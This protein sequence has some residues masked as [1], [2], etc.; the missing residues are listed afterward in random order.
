MNIKFTAYDSATGQ[1][2]YS[3]TASDPEALETSEVSILPGV[4][5]SDGWIDNGQH[6]LPP[7]KPS[8][9]HVFDY[10]TKQWV[11][12]RTLQALKDAKWEEI[13]SSRTDAIDA[14]LVTPYGT[15]DSGP[16]SRTNITNAVLLQ[17]FENEGAPSSVDFTL[18]NNTVISLTR[19]QMINVGL[20][21]GQKTQAAYA[22][23]RELRALIDAA[24]TK[25]EVEAITW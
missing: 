19:A 2:L 10:T 18:A 4:V 6:F 17:S 5:Y 16:V 13:K 25:E 20:L 24:T 12:P 7:P 22:H 11:D 23:A 1:V 9:I 8:E 21:L 3:G 15:F 14:P